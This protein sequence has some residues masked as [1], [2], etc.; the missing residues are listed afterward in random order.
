MMKYRICIGIAFAVTLVVLGMTP[1]LAQ[2][3]QYN[4][5]WAVNSANTV[6]PASAPWFISTVDSYSPYDIG[7]HVS[8]A[9]HPVT[10]APFISYYD[11][12]HK[13]L[14]MAQYVGSGGNCGP[15]DTWSCETVDYAGDVGKYSSIAIDPADNLP[16]ISYYD[17]TNRSLKLAVR[18][19]FEWQLKTI[20]D[21]DFVS[22]GLYSSLKLGSTIHI[23]FY[24]SNLM[25]A[26]SLWYAK[27]VGGGTGNCGGNDYQC[28]CVD[29]GD[30]VGKYASLALD[31]SDQPRIAYYDGGYDSLKYA[32]YEGSWFIRRILA[33]PSG[34]PSGQYASLFVD[35]DNGDLPHIA[36]YD[37]V[38]GKLG[39]AV[40]V[41]SGGNCGM[42]NT[43]TETPLTLLAISRWPTSVFS[44]FCHWP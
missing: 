2:G 24:V 27:Y 44:P 6:S 18:T 22:A 16:I 10:G 41:G 13:D 25:G 14:R 40:Y 33:A 7:Q 4:E 31:S 12:S 23:A 19:T 36:H 42:S 11:A 26:D 15:Q 17:A 28:N 37:S 3:S 9:L 8:V 38:N 20:Y 29:S 30:R 5:D 43:I 34:T 21:P 32:Y 39:Y 1:R 35:V